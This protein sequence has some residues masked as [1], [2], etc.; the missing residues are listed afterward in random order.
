L[1]LPLLLLG[2][3]RRRPWRER[4]RRRDHLRRPW[5]FLKLLLWRRRCYRGRRG[6]GR[7][8]RRGR[9]ILLVFWLLDDLVVVGG[10]GGH[11]LVHGEEIV[12]RV[13]SGLRVRWRRRRR[14]RRH[15]RSRCGRRHER[16]YL[17]PVTQ[18][19]PPV[20]E[21]LVLVLFLLYLRLLLVILPNRVAVEHRGALGLRGQGHALGP[22]DLRGRRREL[23]ERRRGRRQRVDG[24]RRRHHHRVDRGRRRRDPRHAHPAAGREPVRRGG[25]AAPAAAAAARPPR[26][27]TRRARRPCPAATWRTPSA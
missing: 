14:L 22:V 5:I 12:P 27:R 1:P 10:N 21:M 3:H 15:R 6:K 26:A 9:D 17:R 18:P 24:W 4:W 16:R 8:R 2:R 7:A 23:R 19:P 25:A 20:I 13:N 11:P